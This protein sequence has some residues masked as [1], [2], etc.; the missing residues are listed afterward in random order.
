MI[1][2]FDSFVLTIHTPPSDSNNTFKSSFD[3]EEHEEHTSVSLGIREK[4]LVKW[5]YGWKSAIEKSI[6]IYK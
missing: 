1:L 2:R 3:Y 5:F 6:Y 4:K